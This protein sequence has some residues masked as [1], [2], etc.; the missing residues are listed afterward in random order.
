MSSADVSDQTGHGRMD[1][2]LHV[3]T[4]LCAVLP[5]ST[6]K[7]TTSTQGVLKGEERRQQ[8]ERRVIHSD[9]KR[10]GEDSKNVQ[11]VLFKC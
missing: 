2:E 11:I 3:Q 10:S 5:S 6:R 8:M 4:V 9:W 1:V 7:E